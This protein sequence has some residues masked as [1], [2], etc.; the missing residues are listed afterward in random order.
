MRKATGIVAYHG[1]KV[2]ALTAVTRKG[3]MTQLIR[4]SENSPFPYDYKDFY[5][6]YS[7][8]IKYLKMNGFELNYYSDFGARWYDIVWYDVMNPTHHEKFGI[9]VNKLEGR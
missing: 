1:S 2:Y 3:D 8:I 5:S 9:P 4:Y 6:L 7:A